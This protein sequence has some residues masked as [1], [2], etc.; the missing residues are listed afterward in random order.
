MS[1]EGKAELVSTLLS[2]IP[3]K[4]GRPGSPG[5]PLPQKRARGLQRSM[6]AL[7]FG[8]TPRTGPNVPRLLSGRSRDARTWELC[9]DTEA[10]DELT[11]QAE[12]ESSGSAVAAISLLRSSS[13]SALKPNSQKRNIPPKSQST[14]WTKRQK[15]E[16][17][18]SSLARLE[19]SETLP[20]KIS[21]S[22][23]DNGKDG[24]GGLPRSPSGD[25]DK[26]NRIPFEGGG[27]PRRRPL[28]SSRTDKHGNS[29]R[30]LEENLSAQA[31]AV[32]FGI[33]KKR[34]QVSHKETVVF[35]DGENA[36][37]PEDVERFMRGEISP[38]KKGDLD[39]V[40]GLLSL[41]QGNWR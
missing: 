35:E 11:K 3:F 21:Q 9:C 24:N 28:P 30:V 4:S 36:D 29:K 22:K 25:S 7:P 18:H 26:E 40:Q 15:L 5:P 6:S 1:L 16:R 39:C 8:S 32:G 37:V 10:R 41:S 14:G 2:P 19:A 13:N 34:R 23:F 12:N 17:A 20:L 33:D 38:S 31:P 27:N